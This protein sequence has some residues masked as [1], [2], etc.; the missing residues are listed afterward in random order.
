MPATTVEELR[1]ATRI[2]VRTP[3]VVYNYDANGHLTRTRAWTD[4]L[5]N[6]GA[7]ITSEHPLIGE[8]FYIRIMLPD[9]KNQ[10]I[11]CEVMREIQVT[12]DMIGNMFDIRRAYYGIRFVGLA[13]DQILNQIELVD[14]AAMGR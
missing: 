13:S 11:L 3:V 2:G 9:L 14:S 1:S 6:T 12:A 4:D 8:E 10:V 5:S 7:R